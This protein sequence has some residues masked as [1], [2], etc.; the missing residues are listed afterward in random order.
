MFETKEFTLRRILSA[1]LAAREIEQAEMLF[2]NDFKR[3]AGAIAGV[4]LELHL[5]TQC[6]VKGIPYKSTATLNTYI[7]ALY[8][9][10]VIEITEKMLWKP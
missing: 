1:D 8:K 9:E 10:Q 3:A 5:R 6:D 4:A 7:A 2:E